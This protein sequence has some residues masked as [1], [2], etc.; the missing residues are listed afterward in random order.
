LD[1]GFWIVK[2]LPGGSFTNSNVA[3]LNPIGI[4]QLSTNQESLNFSAK[5]L[6]LIILPESSKTDVT[7]SY[8]MTA[9]I[10]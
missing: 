2:A 6:S 5:W 7:L 8:S 9:F 1:F 10:S 4:R 3:S